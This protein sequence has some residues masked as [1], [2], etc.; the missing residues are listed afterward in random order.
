MDELGKARGRKFAAQIENAGW[1]LDAGQ[2]DVTSSGGFWL[3]SY[4]I[5]QGWRLVAQLTPEGYRAMCTGEMLEHAAG[6]SPVDVLAGALSH[7]DALRPEKRD[8]ASSRDLALALALYASHT[9]TLKALP[10][11]Q[12]GLSLHF[13]VFDWH[14]AQGTRILKP[15]AAPHPS[16]ITPAELEV[17]SAR[18]LFE[19]LVKNP[20]EQP[21]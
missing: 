19:H 11:L 3:Y 12:G 20:N 2:E 7:Y 18:V 6:L 9:Q 8:R 14:T 15:G 10:R 16:P 1:V 13:M 17:F 21:A 5:P 4:S